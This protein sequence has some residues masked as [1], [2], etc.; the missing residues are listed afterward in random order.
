ML[1]SLLVKAVPTLSQ[2]VFESFFSTGVN[3]LNRFFSSVL[4]L[5]MGTGPFFPFLGK[6]APP[7]T[8]PGGVVDLKER[9]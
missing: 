9:K 8:A 3:T 1:P 2:K 5:G 6:R 4:F 7:S